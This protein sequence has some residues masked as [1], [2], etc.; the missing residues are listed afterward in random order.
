MEAFVFRIE[1]DGEVL[2]EA[3]IQVYGD[4]PLATLN[5]AIVSCKRTIKTDANIGSGVTIDVTAL[6]MAMADS[7]QGDATIN[8]MIALQVSDRTEVPA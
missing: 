6:L 4:D 1:K 3:P 8:R 5:D 2:V 7:M